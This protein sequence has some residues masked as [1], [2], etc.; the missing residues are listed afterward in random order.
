MK[1]V[2]TFTYNVTAWCAL[3][4]SVRQRISLE[5]PSLGPVNTLQL[6]YVIGIVVFEQASCAV[7]NR[8]EIHPP[9]L[10]LRNR[11][12]PPNGDSTA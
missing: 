12:T 7:V 6:A 11:V 3:K 8:L 10:R 9:I 1:V 4:D 5:V 2:G